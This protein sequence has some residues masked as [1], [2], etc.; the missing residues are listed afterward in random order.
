MIFLVVGALA[1]TG[2]CNFL[3]SGFVAVEEQKRVALGEALEKAAPGAW[4]VVYQGR[5][6]GLVQ[7]AAYAALALDGVQV[8]CPLRAEDLGSLPPGVPEDV[9]ISHYKGVGRYVAG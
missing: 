6:H 1:F 3:E 4:L 5:V 8:G 2:V 7:S 9:A